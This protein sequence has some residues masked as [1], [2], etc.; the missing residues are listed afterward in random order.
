MELDAARVDPA[1]IPSPGCRP[2]VR[3]GEPP[4]QGLSAF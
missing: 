2:G 3:A 4:A 1:L